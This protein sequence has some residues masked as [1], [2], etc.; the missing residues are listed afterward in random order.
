MYLITIPELPNATFSCSPAE[1]EYSITFRLLPSGIT[2]A[3]I[4]YG[5]K[6]IAS[7][8][9]CINNRFIIPYKY[10]EADGNF[11]FKCDNEEYPNY[12]NFNRSC[13]LY[14]MDEDEVASYREGENA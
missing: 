10:L 8:V 2:L 14:F 9:R 1:K 5:G 3:S 6:T 4:S 12:K 11:M 7:S 13:K